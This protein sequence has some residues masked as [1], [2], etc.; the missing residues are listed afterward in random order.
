MAR[1]RY[2]AQGNRVFDEKIGVWAFVDWVQAK[3]RSANMYI[4]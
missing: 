2:D 1:P 4:L 3:K